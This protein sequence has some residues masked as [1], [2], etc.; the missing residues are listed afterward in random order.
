MILGMHGAYI[1]QAM[2]IMLSIVWY[3]SQAW[4]GG[5]CV[6]AMISSWSHSFLMMNNTFPESAHMVTRDFVGFVLFH[7][8]SVPFLVIRPENSKWYVISANIVV[9]FVMLGITLWSV[10]TAGGTGPLFE[11][12]A[13]QPSIL[14]SGWAWVY[15]IVA[16]VGNISAGIVN[17]SDFTRF[18][19]KQGIQVPGMVFSLLVPGMIVPVFGILSASASMEIWKV[20]EPFWNP[21]AIV[22]QWMLDDY[23][24]KARAGAFFCSFG[25][26]LGQVA[27][28]IL[29]NGYAAGMDLAGLFPTYISIR[30]G[31]LIAALLSWAVMPWEFYNTA[32]TFVAVA[33]SFSVFLGPLTGIM[34][35]DYFIIRRQKIQL[36]H[37]YTGSKEGSYWYTYGFNWRGFVAWVVCFV[38]AMPG[39]IANVNAS[40]TVS[41]GL[42]HYY[43]GN[44]LFGFFE[45]AVLYTAFCY[46]FKPKG[47]GLQ[48]DMDV[49]GTFDE[50]LAI[51]K[52]M[53]P[54]DKSSGS[55]G[56]DISGQIVDEQSII[57]GSKNNK[58]ERR[59]E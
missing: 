57:G 7:L 59:L 30:R 56:P 12:G 10:T 14:T 50:N 55:E 24:P 40:V 49:Y 48:D 15:G 46:A 20:E 11:A 58:P 44:Y 28:N 18:A 34:M 32:S 43:L 51:R 39:M 38:P 6:S 53:A 5:L 31:S 26:V 47:A 33:A 23:S 1:G 19:R 36:S 37:L 17:Q 25:F 21:L 35:A 9:F 27:E 52:G 29:G 16:S 54:F 2:R 3:G 42:Y 8:I 41:E 13:R 45:A 22:V 4:L